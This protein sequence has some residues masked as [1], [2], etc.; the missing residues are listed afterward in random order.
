VAPG[1]VVGRL[2]EPLAAAVG[3]NPAR[4]VAV[5]SHDTAS[6]FAAAPATD[7]ARAL[8]ISSG[9]WSLVGRLVPEP[10]TSAAAMAANL[11]NE[12]G[13]GNIRL[14]RNCMG[15]WL[16]QELRRGW[17]HADG[18]DMP[19]AE[20]DRLTAEAPPFAALIDPDDSS[21]YNPPNM[22]QAMADFCRRTGQTMPAGRGAVARMV[23]ES[24]ALKYRM[25]DEMIAGV[26]GSSAA[27]IHIV[28][29]G[30]RNELLNRFTADAAGKP[31]VAGPVEATAIGNL[32]V[33]AMGLGTLRSLA[34]ALPMIRQSFPIREYQPSG[35]PAWRQAYDRF[36]AIVKG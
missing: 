28:G 19:W 34:E 21:F 12:G 30:S 14:L 7:P 36:R 29:G 5:A 13:V 15:G 31:V 35:D 9:T 32:L 24:L 33:Q 8:I 18:R 6:A 22:E 3:L 16:V 11:S 27:V 25:I 10:V 4:L 20:L 26:C 2:R 17:R 23:Y 1:T